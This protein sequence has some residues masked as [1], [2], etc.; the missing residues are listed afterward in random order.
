MPDLDVLENPWIDEA[1]MEWHNHAIVLQTVEVKAKSRPLGDHKEEDDPTARTCEEC[2]TEIETR[3]LGNCKGGEAENDPAVR[4]QEGCFAEEKGPG[5]PKIERD[6]YEGYSLVPR[7]EGEEENTSKT[8]D[9]PVKSPVPPKVILYM[10]K[11]SAELLEVDPGGLWFGGSKL[12]AIFVEGN[13]FR[14]FRT[15]IFV[16][17]RFGQLAIAG[18]CNKDQKGIQDL[19]EW[20][21]SPVERTETNGEAK[22]LSEPVNFRSTLYT[23]KTGPCTIY[24]V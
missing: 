14:V 20:E 1:T 7:F 9:L 19:L 5:V 24:Q 17:F 21:D 18:N 6:A 2:C 16:N 15:L 3:P 12:V 8:M 22:R 23:Y 10:K 13:V 11:A 4:M